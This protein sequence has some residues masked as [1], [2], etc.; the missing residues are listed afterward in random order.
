MPNWYSG[1]VIIRGDIARFRDWYNKHKD[2][3]DGL[4]NSFAQTFAPLSSGKWDFGTACDEWGVKW[5]IGN[6]SM[7]SGEDEGDDEFSFSFDTAWNS[8]VYLWRQ[9]EMRYGVEV[10]ETGYEEQQLEFYKY[11]NGRFICKDVDN[12]WFAENLDFTPSAE[13]L[14]DEELLEDE[15]NDFR[16]DNWCDG[17]EKWEATLSTDHPDWKEIKM[18]V[19]EE[20]QVL[21]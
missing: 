17:M 5:D 9:L 11:H 19:V 1:T 20:E 18:T 12:D 21:H 13:A 8:P 4:E 6:I 3:E 14:K 16:Y 15:K 7:N 2:T 10:E